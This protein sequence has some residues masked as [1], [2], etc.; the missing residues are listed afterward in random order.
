MAN[1][2][3]GRSSKGSAMVTTLLVV[4]VFFIL[5]ITVSTVVT[6]QARGNMEEQMATLAFYVA[7]AGL[8]YATP[9]VMCSFFLYE[10]QAADTSSLRDV[11]IFTAPDYKGKVT[12]E[13]YAS[14]TLPIA[15]DGYNFKCLI[16]SQGR[17]LRNF[18]GEA[19]AQRTIFTE[20]YLAYEKNTTPGRIRT[21][22]RKYYEKNR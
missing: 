6:L 7:D 4:L 22:F 11:E 9:H 5:S 3:G 19:I 2:P 15:V 16:A 20:L 12:V 1:R 10:T 8:R 18:D 14:E 13:I 17:I 21:S